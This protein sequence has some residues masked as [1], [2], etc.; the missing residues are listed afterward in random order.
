VIIND[1][2]V[3][4]CV[5]DGK[6]TALAR[7]TTKVGRLCA[8]AGLASAH[9]QNVDNAHVDFSRV[10]GSTLHSLGEAGASGWLHFATTWPE[11]VTQDANDLPEHDAHA[12]A[13]VLTRWLELAELFD[14]LPELPRF[15]AV[16]EK[17]AHDLVAGPA[18]RPLVLH[19]DLH[20]KQL[21]WDGST[22]GVLDVD[23]AAR[24]EVALDLGNLLAHADLRL[25]Q[26]I[27]TPSTSDTIAGHVNTVA[28]ALNVNPARLETYRR[29]AL[30][31]LA[32][33]YAFRPTSKDWLPG[34]V[35]TCVTL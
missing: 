2:Y 31:R 3:R 13:T 24:G 8:I 26:N 20:D 34:W 19:R 21:L 6:A 4:K 18:D 32:C 11:L 16:V 9:V 15:R 25:T 5:R 10:N 14:A 17:T 33:V 12:E 22:L 29:A 28:A 23:T 30:L 7:V 27:F 35:D 1:T